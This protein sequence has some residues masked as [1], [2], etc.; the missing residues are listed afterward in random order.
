MRGLLFLSAWSRARQNAVPVQQAIGRIAE[1]SSDRMLAQIAD[2]EY[3]PYLTLGEESVE[4]MIEAEREEFVRTLE[5]LGVADDVTELL[6]MRSRMDGVARELKDRLVEGKEAVRSN[7]PEV[8]KGM[9]EKFSDP[10]EIDDW[11]V[12]RFEDLSVER[13]RKLGDE[14]LASRLE[15][16]FSKRRS[17]REE[18]PEDGATLREMEDAFLREADLTNGGVAPA[19]A[20][21]VRKMRSE[22]MIRMAA[23]ARRIGMDLAAIQYEI[24]KIRGIV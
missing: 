23:G 2:T 4:R 19:M 6:F 16:L 18:G 8:E 10:A 1:E 21:I 22:R 7:D 20:L 14:K 3:G 24:S 12:R 5:R 11:S 13:A 9:R 15:S 17:M